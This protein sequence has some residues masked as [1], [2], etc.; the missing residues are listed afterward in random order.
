MAFFD[1]PVRVG[2]LAILTLSTWVAIDGAVFGQAALDVCFNDTF[3]SLCWYVPEFS[4]LWRPF[5]R[6]TTPSPAVA[7]V[8]AYFAVVY[9]WMAAPLVRDLSPRTVAMVGAGGTRSA[10][11]SDGESDR[12]AIIAR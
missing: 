5:V 8:G 9:I 1:V 12:A 6:F 10:T 3:A 7:M 4:P 11:A 2:I